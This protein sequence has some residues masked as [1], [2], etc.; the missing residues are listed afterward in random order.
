MFHDK[1]AKTIKSAILTHNTQNVQ[2]QKET[3]KNIFQLF[4]PGS[5]NRI[6]LLKQNI[7]EAIRSLAPPIISISGALA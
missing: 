2:D 4:G 5:Y 1:M 3:I 6:N 7:K